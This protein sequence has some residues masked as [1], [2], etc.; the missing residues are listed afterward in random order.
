MTAWPKEVVEEALR[1]PPTSALP[2]I[3]T[4]P[5]LERIQTAL[6]HMDIVYTPSTTLEPCD[7][8]WEALQDRI[9]A[10]RADP[11]ERAFVQAWLTR[12]IESEIAWLEDTPARRALLDQAASC[13]A[14]MSSALEA[15]DLV[16]E[17]TF[18][19]E[20]ETIPSCVQGGPGMSV[21][22]TVRDAALPPSD[23]QSVQG[24]A[25]AADAV[26]MQTYASSI[27]MCDL[28][29]RRPGAWHRALEAEASPRSTLTVMELGAGTGIVGMVVA[30]ALDQHISPVQHATV[31]LTDYHADVMTNLLHNV[32]EHL[33]VAKDRVEV[34]CEALDWRALH[35][36]VYPDEACGE[37][38][39]C[40]IPPPQSISLLL[41]ADPIY[42]P[43]HATWLLPAIVYLLALPTTDPDARAHILLPVRV[44]GRLAELYKTVDVA[45]ARQA[46]R[47]G[48][49][50]CRQSQ[51][52][53]PRR[54]GLG[55]RD[56][57][58]Y[59]WTV[60]AWEKLV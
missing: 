2:R 10:A 3:R 47:Q 18:P 20:A 22:I 35:D 33:H 29:V 48:F 54:Y 49:R 43:M 53:L 7:E 57:R 26:G 39:A 41:V 4:E 14:S 60:L 17:F 31:Y 36:L 13:M 1:L 27:L 11:T 19:M 42:S 38:V 34:V 12:L 46:P 32:K 23:A 16:R 45:L 40:R 25:E 50:L 6:Q 5:P 24:A 15:G 8:E 52:H 56:E 30:R 58:E 51:T 28:F 55:R 21:S 37:T 9:D 44:A 59:I